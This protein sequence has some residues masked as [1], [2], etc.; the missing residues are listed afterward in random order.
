VKFPPKALIENI[1]RGL[2]NKM[3][4]DPEHLNYKLE[5]MTVKPYFRRFERVRAEIIAD[6]PE[7][8]GYLPPIR[9]FRPTFLQDR[10]Q[11]HAAVYG[12][13]VKGFMDDMHETLDALRVLDMVVGEPDVTTQG[14]FLAGQEF[15][16]FRKIEAIL[17]S[18][19]KELCVLDAYASSDLLEH[20]QAKADGVRVRLLTGKTREF[21]NLGVA[22]T[23]F[24]AQHGDTL[25]VRIGGR[26]VHDRYVIVDSDRCYHFGHSLKDAGARGFMFSELG[27]QELRDKLME[28]YEKE[29]QAGT[30]LP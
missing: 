16:A 9:Q 18:A 1:M 8:E 4:P 21:K 20:F 2:A 12:I 23:K 7:I 15:D 24:N 22:V 26:D 17:S 30:P 13:D 28:S 5:W 19:K 14:L 10:G 27:L 29:W 11:H 25:E 3:P 6:H